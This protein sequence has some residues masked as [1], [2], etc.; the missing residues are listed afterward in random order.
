MSKKQYRNTN[1][2]ADY[3]GQYYKFA[4]ENGLM[5]TVIKGREGK[6]VI[7]SDNQ[8]VVEFINC[9]YLGIDIHPTVIEAYKNI[10][11]KWGVNFCCARSRFTIEPLFELEIQLSNLFKG[12]AITFPSVTTTHVSVMPLVASGNLLDPKK[13]LNIR[14]IFDKFS[15]ASMQ[16]LKPILATESHIS[17][18]NHN[19]L[20]MLESIVKSSQLNG[21]TCVYVADGIYSMGGLCPIDELMELSRRLGFYLY[22][23]DAHGTS[24]FGDL[25]EGSILSLINGGIPDNVLISFCLSKG[26]GCNGGGIL[27]PFEWQERLVRTYGQIYAFS[28][29]LDFSVVNA[30]LA[31]VELHQNKTVRE[32]Q[33]KLRHNVKYFDDLMGFSLPFSPIRMI[34]IGD[35]NKALHF[36]QRI[37][38]KGFFLSVVFFPIVKRNEAQLRV[39]IAANHTMEEIH[40]LTNAIKGILDEGGLYDVH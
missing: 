26:F 24:I 20:N 4:V 2:V 31:S 9:S 21:E 40:Q 38:E 27:L 14:L 30:C 36:C 28:A 11:P 32:L 22:I 34:K 5:Q 29:A 25:G 7:L 33:K 3:A 8:E 18:I 16:F 17:V 6:R 1:F 10:D 35:E 39:C 13:N 19:D 15:H 23:D 12:R 37:V